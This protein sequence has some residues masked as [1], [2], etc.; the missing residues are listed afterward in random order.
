MNV[1][2]IIYRIYLFN[3][4][5]YLFWYMFYKVLVKGSNFLCLRKIFLAN[6]VNRHR[7]L[8]YAQSLLFSLSLYTTVC[9]HYSWRPLFIHLFYLE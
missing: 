9:T 8:A 3:V 5:K 2:K 7:R 6:E 1:I 4:L